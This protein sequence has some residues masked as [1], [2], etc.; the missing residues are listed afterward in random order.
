[1]SLAL[2]A[3]IAA[4][5][6]HRQLTVSEASEFTLSARRDSDI[7]VDFGGRLWRL[8]ADGGRAEP[9][10]PASEL[11]RRPAL[12][13]DGQ[14]LVYQVLRDGFFQLA[15]IDTDGGN[16]RQL[17]HGPW[18]HREPSWS[19][20]G[21]RL[22]LASDRGGNYGIWELDIAT[23]ELRLLA[24]TSGA[25]REPAFAPTSDALA[26]I[27]RR[28]LRNTLYLRQGTDPA[29]ALVT[30]DTP[31]S[32]P[33]WRPDG[34]IVSYVAETAQG[35]RLQMVVLSEPP[36]V[37]P[38]VPG[39]AAL[40]SP[41]SWRDRN[42]LIYAADGQIRRRDFDLPPSTGIPFEL[43]L[44]VGVAGPPPVRRL[45]RP[46]G[47]QPVGALAGLAVLADG[48]SVVSA[49]GDLWE[50]AAD[51]QLQRSLTL[52]AAANREPAVS[53]DGRSLA[54]TSERSGNAQIWLMEL[55]S[56][57]TRR[58]TDEANGARY[59]AW[60]ADGSHLAYVAGTRRTRLQRLSLATGKVV[61]L[62]TDLGSPT[63]LAWSPDGRSIALVLTRAGNPQLLLVGADPDS[64]MRRMTLPLA[65]VAGATAELQWSANGRELLLASAAG[66]RVL[67]VL[68]NGLISAEWQDL[69]SDP[70]QAGRWLPDGATVLFTADGR[71][72][73][74][75]AGA[76]REYLPMAL[77]WQ[78]REIEGRTVIRAGRVFDGLGDEYLLYQD[79]I[80][81]GPRIVAVQPW[82]PEPI[83][84]GTR[85]IDVRNAT[86]LP[87]L[88]DTAVDLSSPDASAGRDAL[89][90]G[91]TTVHALNPPGAQ[92]RELAER[93]QA[94]RAGPRLLISPRACTPGEATVTPDSGALRLCPTGLQQL[95]AVAAA[96]RDFGVPIWSETWLTAASGLVDVIVPPPGA[97]GMSPG[98]AFYA[99]AIDVLIHS[100]AALVS[101]LAG[102]GLPLL[103]EDQPAL[104]QQAGRAAAGRLNRAQGSPQAWLRDRQRLLGR[105]S[106]GGGRLV[107]GSN[108]DAAA[109]GLALHAEIGW[110]IRGGLSPAQVLRMATADAARALG[111]QEDIGTIAPG[112]LADLVIVD[113]D[114]LRRPTEPLRI[115]AVI[116][117][118]ERLDLS[119]RNP[120]T[121]MLEKFTP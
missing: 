118:G 86:V 22:A 43:T 28:G 40:P 13:P 58:L 16:A 76:A 81:D 42:G 84:E 93:W 66:L 32:A 85:L 31:L 117:E 55:A 72:G 78:P 37:K 112:R 69:G 25:A 100:G 9:L 12:A 101:G 52:D 33:A 83:P 116:L 82:T 87:G 54:F 70:V 111:L 36:V 19:A 14:T 41:V 92:M 5:V 65:A 63:P 107:A 24:A 94:R 8:P 98:G 57:L 89:G 47:P 113:G 2:I 45:A 68:E 29:R 4:A 104:L 26:Y 110:L 30:A 106:A 35:P 27:G 91:V 96:A 71:L 105:L 10:T 60:S 79:I 51:G 73:R 6:D 90:W 97:P 77:T 23:G 115:H 7:F 74:A 119:P 49:L 17:T 46:E 61:T 39:E 20:D 103:A 34:S 44:D 11:A 99:D 109:L 38:L 21:R 121:R 50:V 18:H 95:A 64:G 48:R 114:P 53:P 88:I 15:L 108:A 3:G 102:T 120:S 59:P 1:L 56:G 75:R 62:S 80:L 67:P